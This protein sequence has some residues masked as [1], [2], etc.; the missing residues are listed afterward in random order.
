MAEGVFR[1]AAENTDIEVSSA[2]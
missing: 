2:G 1:K